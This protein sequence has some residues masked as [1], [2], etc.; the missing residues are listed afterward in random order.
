MIAL[1]ADKVDA[2]AD[3]AEDGLW[4]RGIGQDDNHGLSG[5]ALMVTAVM[6]VMELLQMHAMVI[7]VP[8]E[9]LAEGALKAIGIM[10]CGEPDLH[11]V[12]REL[13][14]AFDAG[15]EIGRAE[16]AAEAMGDAEGTA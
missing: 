2:A 15:L 8:M 1:D 9:C 11:A 14:T 7:Q 13:M 4:Q 5:E 6:G 3:I 16:R 12:R 10:A